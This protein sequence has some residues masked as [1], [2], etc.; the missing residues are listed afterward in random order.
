MPNVKRS[1]NAALAAN[2]V[3]SLLSADLLLLVTDF[4]LGIL[5]AQEFVTAVAHNGLVMHKE[6]GKIDHVL[7]TKE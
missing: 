7:L 3:A 5:S 2:T 6:L 1:V 4:R